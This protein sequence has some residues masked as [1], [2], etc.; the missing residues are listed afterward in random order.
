MLQWKTIIFFMIL[1]LG[2]PIGAS[3]VLKY[4]SGR[5]PLDSRSEY[6][7]FVNHSVQS[8]SDGIDSLESLAESEAFMAD[9]AKAQYVK[10]QSLKETLAP[11]RM[12]KIAFSYLPDII[13][14]SADQ[15]IVQLHEHI[16]LLDSKIRILEKAFQA[17]QR[18]PHRWPSQYHQWQAKNAWPLQLKTLIDEKRMLSARLESLKKRLFSETD[19]F[20]LIAELDPETHPELALEVEIESGWL[21]SKVNFYPIWKTSQNWKRGSDSPWF[22]LSENM[23]PESTKSAFLNGTSP[24]HLLAYWNL[25][26]QA[27]R[28]PDQKGSSE[29]RFLNHR[30]ALIQGTSI[31]SHMPSPHLIAFAGPSDLTVDG[32]LDLAC[33]SKN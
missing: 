18:H 28:I 27:N 33:F 11:Y 8:Q 4:E 21:K 16:Q 19:I 17:Q 20:E 3:D 32:L 23:I 25:F 6:C 2:V 22:S 9:S 5:Q 30:S 26:Q 12:R 13:A 10:M 7:E 29:L 1:L 15:K 14:K 31:T 24:R